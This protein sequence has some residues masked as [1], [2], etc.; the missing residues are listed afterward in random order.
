MSDHHSCSG[1]H[2]HNL[3]RV[4]LELTP[5]GLRLNVLG[6]V[7]ELFRLLREENYAEAI[8]LTDV[9]GQM[10]SSAYLGQYDRLDESYEQA[11]VDRFHHQLEDPDVLS[12][13][14]KGEA[15]E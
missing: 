13:L 3:D 14:E 5:S 1:E 15:S 2:E 8:E 7:G 4:L 6:L 10:L 12:E 9:A 11:V